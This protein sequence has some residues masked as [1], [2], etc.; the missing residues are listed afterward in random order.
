MPPASPPMPLLASGSRGGTLLLG[1]PLPAGVHDK[2]LSR[3]RAAAI[4][5]DGW[6]VAAADA[7]GWLHVFD[8]RRQDSHLGSLA[9]PAAEASDS[10]LVAH[11]SEGQRRPD[12]LAICKA[13]CFAR[14][15]GSRD[16]L[17]CAVGNRPRVVDPYTLKILARLAGHDEK[18]TGVSSG[19]TWALTQ[20]SDALLLW[21]APD[22]ATAWRAMRRLQAPA[23]GVV[24]AQ[25]AP[26]GAAV[27]V[28]YHD[29][30]VAVWEP[31]SGHLREELQ[32]LPGT[33]D[34]DAVLWSSVAFCKGCLAVVGSLPR[35]LG[36][37]GGGVLAIWSDN[38]VRKASSEPLQRSFQSVQPV[39][40][41]TAEPIRQML[42]REAILYLG[43]SRRVC[44]LNV[45]SR[46]VLLDISTSKSGPGLA[47]LA[48]DR[49]GHRVVLGGEDGSLE[50]KDLAED[51][52]SARRGRVKQAWLP[53]GSNSF[54]AGA[55]R[56]SRSQPTQGAQNAKDGKEKHVL[57]VIEAARLGPARVPR[58]G[59]QPQK[60]QEAAALPAGNTDAPVG[61]FAASRS[62]DAVARC[63][64]AVTPEDKK[65]MCFL[66]Q[67]G[68]YPAKQRAAVWRRLLRLPRNLA[69]HAY[70]ME[71]AG[72]VNQRAEELV[73]LA[74]LK[75]AAESTLV[76]TIAALS[77]WA[78]ALAE[79]QQLPTLV[80]PFAQ[81]FADDDVLAFEAAA[82][83]FLD[84]GTP[85][86]ETYPSPPLESLRAAQ[87]VLE[88]AD[89]E[90]VSQLEALAQG[91]ADA[92]AV[93]VQEDVRACALWRLTRT[94]LAQCL[95]EDAW[96]AIWDHMV[97]RW[98]EGPLLLDIAAAAVLRCLRGALLAVPAGTRGALQRLLETPQ[99]IPAAALLQ[100]FYELRARWR[101]MDTKAAERSRR[102]G[103]ELPLQP[104]DVY[105]PLLRGP[106]FVLDYLSLDRSRVRKEADAARRARREAAEVNELLRELVEEEERLQAE[107]AKML[108][109]EEARQEMVRLDDARIEADR[110]RVAQE[111]VASRIER[112]H[113]ACGALQ[114][115]LRHEKTFQ[116]KEAGR[117]AEEVQRQRRLHAQDVDVRREEN[118]LE[119]V[120]SVAFQQLSA[121]LRQ[122][123]GSALAQQLRQQV[124]SVLLAR[125]QE[126]EL[127]RRN[128][129][130]EDEAE[131]ARARGAAEES[132][133]VH[134]YAMA[135]MERREVEQHLALEEQERLAQRGK[136]QAARAARQAVIDARREADKKL[137]ARKQW[138]DE[139]I[140]EVGEWTEAQRRE[141]KAQSGRRQ[142][143][144]RRR[145]FEA[146]QTAQQTLGQQNERLQEV[147]QAEERQHF[148]VRLRKSVDADTTAAAAFEDQVEDIVARLS[149]VQRRG[150]EDQA[151]LER[152]QELVTRQDHQWF[153]AQ[154]LASRLID[155]DRRKFLDGLGIDL[156]GEFDVG[157]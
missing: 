95:P 64:A 41:Q 39:L 71:Q 74:G 132:V 104:G 59:E 35:A 120:E 79:M 81:V 69:A 151:L 68:S 131:F 106:H 96:F 147:A 126:D 29:A 86:L 70:L 51:F 149:A 55:A 56:R 33:V 140:R 3:V 27:A 44:A 42:A 155:E 117:L 77:A 138:L 48:A 111:T 98:R 73:L 100:E 90:L 21:S 24:A 118:A 109:A 150:H 25:L 114:S 37:K 156:S 91:S 154:S 60:Q 19:G 85:L 7:A 92:G 49:Q 20:S 8:L 157:A 36:R 45:M 31:A 152:R 84:W 94:A 135:E 124:R 121:L 78:P 47:C 133:K 97:A 72:G 22:P 23:A 112:V 139:T 26:C 5:F 87:A 76:R 15:G 108:R 4:S 2:A 28:L 17:L 113:A 102:P 11:E 123:R 50:W 110:R 43:H 142:E 54:G 122:H 46:Q 62:T 67:H 1:Q 40:L 128:Q 34:G 116:E 119:E 30:R 12:S 144:Q 82:T 136:V 143:M 63:D 107:Q 153:R 75:P 101:A 127:A 57:R 99:V 137:A 61:F 89:S 93:E 83:F 145:L 10:Q 134:Q 65:L 18:V 52:E 129:R 53:A 115:A 14:V 148:E 16:E 80:K 38:L 103:L 141:A 146:A 130:L 125:D 66:R 105:R 6:L 58:C 32:A 9:P 88:V 13:L